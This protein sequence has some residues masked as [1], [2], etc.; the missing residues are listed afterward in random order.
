M[1]MVP[2]T[3]PNNPLMERTRLPGEIHRLPSRGVF[4]TNG[5][6]D[7]NVRDGEVQVFPMTMIDEITAKSPD[8]LFSGDAIKQVI[9]RCVPQI[10]KPELL[11]AKD[12]DF[13]M[14]VLRKAS[15][16]DVEI[17]YKHLCPEAKDHSYIVPVDDMIRAARS[18]DPTTVGSKFSVTMPNNMVVKVAPMKFQTVVNML[19]MTDKNTAPD[20]AKEIAVTTLL[21]IIVAVDEI[22]DKQMIKEWLTTI[23]VGWTNEIDK[24]M[25]AAQ[26]DWGTDMSF[27]FKC[28]DC[29]A[30]V[31][32]VVP[33]NPLAFFI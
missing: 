31:K 25:G 12:V 17:E 32:T 11:L 3:K 14:L 9:K 22:T 33:M 21:D 18:L 30:E 23:P 5:E 26:N 10:L 13:L 29:G 16:G 20:V 1:N 6:L 7:P 24:A 27:R 8:L 19:Q 28:K 15:Y 4:Y 2:P